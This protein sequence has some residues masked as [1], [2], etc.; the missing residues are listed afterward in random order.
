MCKLKNIGKVFVAL[1][2]LGLEFHLPMG[3]LQKRVSRSVW[4]QVGH[5]KHAWLVVARQNKTTME[6]KANI[7]VL[8]LFLF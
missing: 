6:D 4:G 8:L 3:T 1:N 2:S 5:E 7:V